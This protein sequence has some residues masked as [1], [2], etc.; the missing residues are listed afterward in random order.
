MKKN[1]LIRKE[2][3][4]KIF[5]ILV[6]YMFM[7]SGINLEVIAQDDYTSDYS[8]STYDWSSPDIEWDTFPFEADSSYVQWDQVT[9]TEDF[10][11]WDQVNYNSLTSTQIDSFSPEQLGQAVTNM[12]DVNT[13]PTLFNAFL[14]SQGVTAQVSTIAGNTVEAV[15]GGGY[16]LR[17]GENTLNLAS[18]PSNVQSISAV[19]S[20]GD[21]GTPGFVLLKPGES[22]VMSGEDSFKVTY[23]AD[24]NPHMV[25]IATGNEITATG[26]VQ[27]TTSPGNVAQGERLITKYTLE[28]GTE[29]TVT[30]FQAG[31]Q[32]SVTSNSLT[33]Q[34]ASRIDV[35]PA[36]GNM[37]YSI[38]VF[39]SGTGVVRTEGN[40]IV[41]DV[42]HGELTVSDKNGVVLDR[43]SGDVSTTYDMTTQNLEEFTLNSKDSTATIRGHLT[44][45]NDGN[46]PQIYLTQYSNNGE[47][48]RGVWHISAMISTYDSERQKTNG[49]TDDE[50]VS[51]KQRTID[52]TQRRIDQIDTQLSGTITDTYRSQLER[53]K[54]ELTEYSS[55]LEKV[56]TVTGLTNY[57]NDQ[58]TSLE[59]ENYRIYSENPNTGF[60]E[61]NQNADSLY[62]PGS[63][64]TD[65]IPTGLV[66]LVDQSSYGIHRSS[67]GTFNDRISFSGSQSGVYSIF[68]PPDY[69]EASGSNQQTLSKRGMIYFQSGIEGLT[70]DYGTASITST[71]S[72]GS[73]G[74]IV[75]TTGQNSE[76]DTYTKLWRQGSITS[77]VADTG[78]NIVGPVSN[79]IKTSMIR[80]D[81]DGVY[82]VN[83][84]VDSEQSA[85]IKEPSLIQQL[86]DG[87]QQV[88][89]ATRGVLL[90]TRAINDQMTAEQLAAVQQQLQ[91]FRGTPEQVKSFV[92][93]QITQP[94]SGQL[95]DTYI[96]INLLRA[97]GDTQALTSLLGDT[98]LSQDMQNYL[99]QQIVYAY[100]TQGDRSTV[101]SLLNQWNPDGQNAALTA[102]RNQIDQQRQLSSVTPG[103]P[104]DIDQL[105]SI[106]ASGSN[107][108]LAAS[109]QLSQYYTTQAEIAL[110]SNDK[111]LAQQYYE[112]ALNYAE[113]A[114][115]QFTLGLE[116][117]E[118]DL[119]TAGYVNVFD[120]TN[121]ASSISLQIANVADQ[122]AKL[123]T[124]N[125]LV[126]APAIEENSRLVLAI[127][128]SNI[129]AQQYLS[130]SLNSRQLYTENVRSWDAFASE[131]SGNT[132]LYTEASIGGMT[133]RRDTRQYN[134][135]D[136]KYAEINGILSSDSNLQQQYQQ[137][138]NNVYVSAVDTH[139]RELIEQEQY[140]SAINEYQKLVDSSTI[141]SEIRSS[142][143]QQI[144]SLHIQIAS[145]A[146]EQ[147]DYTTALTQLGQVNSQNGATS[148][149]IKSARLT[150]G[151]I[152]NN[153]NRYDEA[154]ASF[155]EVIRIDSQN[156]QA[157]EGLMYSYS[158]S[159]NRAGVTEQA[160]VLGSIYQQK[161][162]DTSLTM[163]QRIE[164]ATLSA[165]RYVTA[166]TIEKSVQV[167][168]TLAASTT[169][170]TVRSEI[171]TDIANLVRTQQDNSAS[172]DYYQK[173]I[174]EDSTNMQALLG[175]AEIETQGS[176]PERERAAQD[177]A[178]IRTDIEQRNQGKDLEDYSQEDL[179]LIYRVELSTS[180]NLDRT[181]STPI[182]Y[183][184]KGI[185][186]TDYQ[187]VYDRE[188]Q[189]AQFQSAL[190]SANN[191]ER[192]ATLLFNS[193]QTA[194]DEADTSEERLKAQSDM[195]IATSMI[196]GAQQSRTVT[197]LYQHNSIQQSQEEYES[198]QGWFSKVSGFFGA[199]V[200]FETTT[201]RSSFLQDQINVYDSLSSSERRSIDA[202]KSDRLG[203]NLDQTQAAVGN[204]YE[205]A[206]PDTLEE[207][208]FWFTQSAAKSGKGIIDSVFGT[209]LTGLNAYN[210]ASTEQTE[211]M[212]GLNYR[213][214]LWSRNIDPDTATDTQI[215][216]VFGSSSNIATIKQSL[217]IARNARSDNIESLNSY[218]PSE[219]WIEELLLPSGFQALQMMVV[220]EGISFGSGLVKSQVARLALSETSWISNS[221]IIAQRVVQTVGAPFEFSGN[222]GQ[223]YETGLNSLMKVSTNEGSQFTWRGFVTSYTSDFLFNRG[224]EEIV[225]TPGYGFLGEAV[226]GSAG[227]NL[228]DWVESAQ[229]KGDININIQTAYNVDTGTVIQVQQ[230]PSGFDFQQQQSHLE[231]QGYQVQPITETDSTIGLT[232][233]APSGGSYTYVQQGSNLHSNLAIVQNNQVATLIPATTIPITTPTTPITTTPVN[234]RPLT[235]VPVQVVS[236]NTNINNLAT[237]IQ[238]QSTVGNVQVVNS[239]TI[240]YTTK[241]GDINIV[242][243]EGTQ[244]SQVT[245]SNGAV[246]NVQSQVS[247][248]QSIAN[249]IAQ[250]RQTNPDALPDYLQTDQNQVNIEEGVS[251]G[252][253][254]TSVLTEILTPIGQAIKTK[255]LTSQTTNN[256]KIAEAALLVMNQQSRP[257]ALVSLQEM[258]L[259]DSNLNPVVDNPIISD[260]VTRSKEAILVNAPTMQST[261]V[262]SQTQ[263]SN[264]VESL[265]EIQQNGNYENLETALEPALF[266]MYQTGLQQGESREAILSK[267]VEIKQQQITDLN[268]F[269]AKLNQVASSF[270]EQ[271]SL[272]ALLKDSG[273]SDTTI[274]NLIDSGITTT[275]SLVNLVQSNPS[276]LTQINGVDSNTAL[277][278]VSSVE[279][280]T[281]QQTE[282]TEQPANSDATAFFFQNAKGLLDQG[283]SPSRLRQALTDV[284]QNPENAEQIMKDL[285]TE[286]R[287]EGYNVQMETDLRLA[288]SQA[289]TPQTTTELET[290]MRGT[291]QT[292]TPTV[293]EVNEVV[294]TPQTPTQDTKYNQP[295]TADITSEQPITIEISAGNT[296][297]GST[298]N[299]P[300]GRVVVGDGVVLRDVTINAQEIVLGQNVVQRNVQINQIKPVEQKPA[301]IGD[302]IQQMHAIQDLAQKNLLLDQAI[303][304]ANNVDTNKQYTDLEKYQLLDDIRA[305]G[306]NL[307][308]QNRLEDA[309]D[310]YQKG[311]ELSNKLG[312]DR[313][314]DALNS[315]LDSTNSELNGQQIQSPIQS[316]ESLE[317]IIDP[318]RLTIQLDAYKAYLDGDL[319]A[320]DILGKIYPSLIELKSS[321]FDTNTGKEI[322]QQ[323]KLDQAFNLF[324]KEFLTFVEQQ[325]ITKDNIDPIILDYKN[326]RQA[327]VES[328]DKQ[329]AENPQSEPT[330]V[331][332]ALRDN[333]L[334][335][336]RHAVDIIANRVNEKAF[337]EINTNRQLD[338]I[339]SYYQT[340]RKILSVPSLAVTFLGLNPS[341]QFGFVR[342]YETSSYLN[343]LRSI[344][345]PQASQLILKY[346]TLEK[347]N[348][349]SV[350]ESQNLLNLLMTEV[351]FADQ[352]GDIGKL[353]SYL[354]NYY[355]EL[356]VQINIKGIVLK[357]ASPEIKGSILRFVA[358]TL[359]DLDKDFISDLNEF[360]KS[361]ISWE[362]L[363]KKYPQYSDV[364]KNIEP[365]A[366]SKL[367]IAHIII[368]KDGKSYEVPVLASNFVSDKTKDSLGI[369]HIQGNKKIVVVNLEKEGFGANKILESLMTILHETDHSVAD[370]ISPTPPS[371]SNKQYLESEGKANLAAFSFIRAQNAFLTKYGTSLSLTSYSREFSETTHSIDAYSIGYIIERALRDYLSDS[372]FF[373]MYNQEGLPLTDSEFRQISDDIIA[374]VNSHIS[375]IIDLTNYP[376]YQLAKI[377]YNNI[378]NKEYDQALKTLGEIYPQQVENLKDSGLDSQSKVTR[379]YEE[380]FSQSWRDLIAKHSAQ[381]QSVESYITR[382]KEIS[383]RLHGLYVSNP[384][385]KLIYVDSAANTQAIADYLGVKPEDVPDFIMFH[386]FFH[387]FANQNKLNLDP[388]TEEML[389]DLF[390]RSLIN[391]QITNDELEIFKA[392]SG[393]SLSPTE[394]LSQTKEQFT[395][396]PASSEEITNIKKAND[397][398]T[399]VLQNAAKE[400]QSRKSLIQERLNQINLQVT[401]IFAK[402]GGPTTEDGKI[403]D[404][405]IQE[406]TRLNEQLSKI[407]QLEPSLRFNLEK[408]IISLLAPSY[409]KSVEFMYTVPGTLEG[410][411]HNIGNKLMPLGFLMPSLSKGNRLSPGLSESQKQEVIDAAKQTSVKV[412]ALLKAYNTIRALQNNAIE[413][414]S[415]FED[416]LERDI[417]LFLEI[418][419][420]HDAFK[421][422][423][424]ALDSFAKDYGSYLSQDALETIAATLAPLKGTSDMQ[425]KDGLVSNFFEPSKT[426]VDDVL[427]RG[428]SYCQKCSYEHSGQ[429]T[430]YETWLRLEPIIYNFVTNSERAYTDNLGTRTS[431]DKPLKI[432]VH[433][434]VDENGILTLTYE[435]TAGGIDT[436][437]LFAKLQNLRKEPQRIEGETDEQFNQR[438]RESIFLPG[439]TTKPVTESGE[440]GIGLDFVS[441]SIKYFKGTLSLEPVIVDGKEQGTRFIITVPVE[442]IPI[443]ETPVEQ[444]AQQQPGLAPELTQQGLDELEANLLT[445]ESKIMENL[446]RKYPDKD[447]KQSTTVL[448][449]GF[450]SQKLAVLATVQNIASEFMIT[451]S[452]K[453]LLN[454]I[455][456]ITSSNDNNEVYN[457]ALKQDNPFVSNNFRQL[458]I[459]LQKMFPVNKIAE[460]TNERD[461]TDPFRGG[462]TFNNAE[463]NIHVIVDPQYASLFQPADIPYSDYTSLQD[464]LDRRLKY[465]SIP[466]LI[467]RESLID[468]ISTVQAST[469]VKGITTPRNLEPEIQEP[470]AE[471]AQNKPGL[472]PELTDEALKEF[473]DN[474]FVTLQKIKDSMKTEFPG[475]SVVNA[476]IFLYEDPENKDMHLNSAN[477]AM[478]TLIETLG[479]K[480]DLNPNDIKILRFIFGIGSETIDIQLRIQQM[481]W[482]A[483]H[484]S[485]ELKHVLSII[486]NV[487]SQSKVSERRGI[488]HQLADGKDTFSNMDYLINSIFLYQDMVSAENVFG[489]GSVY[490]NIPHIREVESLIEGL[491][492]KQGGT[493]VKGMTTPENIEPEIQEPSAE[494]IPQTIQEQSRLV[495]ELTQQGL[496][497]LEANLL[498]LESKIM[499]NLARKYPDK[500]VKQSI[501]VLEDGFDSQKLA[502]LALVENIASKFRITDS[503]MQLLRYIFRITSSND[504]NEI[505]NWAIKQDNPF[506]SNNFRQLLKTLETIFNQKGIETRNNQRGSTD[507]FRGGD[508]FNNAETKINIIVNPQYAN[509]FQ[510]ADIPYSDY[511]SL[512]D[513]LVRRLKYNSIPDLSSR[514]SLIDTISTVQASTVVKGMTIPENPANYLK[515]KLDGI[516][517]ATN[518]KLGSISPNQAETDEDYDRR[519]RDSQFIQER[520]N[521]V[522]S[523]SDLSGSI[524]LDQAYEQ[525]RNVYQSISDYKSS[526]E[527]DTQDVITLFQQQIILYFGDLNE[528]KISTEKTVVEL[529]EE[530]P[531]EAI[532]PTAEERI[533]QQ[534]QELEDYLDQQLP[535]DVEEDFVTFGIQR[536]SSGEL[537]AAD[538]TKINSIQEYESYI[539]KQRTNI[540]YQNT[541]D[542]IEPYLPSDTRPIVETEEYSQEN[543]RRIAVDPATTYPGSDVYAVQMPQLIMEVSP[544]Q[545]NF[546]QEFLRAAG[547]RAKIALDQN[548]FSFA[549][550]YASQLSDLNQGLPLLPSQSPISKTNSQYAELYSMLQSGLFENSDEKPYVESME[551]NPNLAIYSRPYSILGYSF[552]YSVGKGGIFGQDTFIV[553]HIGVDKDQA[554]LKEL[555]RQWDLALTASTIEERTRAIAEF[556]WLFM[557]SNPL[558]RGGASLGDALSLA[559][560]KANNIPWRTTYSRVDFEALSTSREDYVAQR[561]A[562]LT[563]S[564]LAKPST[565]P[566]TAAETEQAL[567][568]QQ[569]EDATTIQPDGSIKVDDSA[570]E[571]L[572]Q[573]TEETKDDLAKEVQDKTPQKD[574]CKGGS[575]SCSLPNP[576]SQ[577]SQ[578]HR[579][580]VETA[581]KE[582]RDETVLTKAFLA[583]SNQ[584]VIDFFSLNKYNVLSVLLGL[585]PAGLVDYVTSAAAKQ[586]FRTEDEARAYAESIIKDI[587][588]FLDDTFNGRI[589]IRSFDQMISQTDTDGTTFY[590]PANF[591][592]YDTQ[593]VQNRLDEL[594]QDSRTIVLI[595]GITNIEQLFDENGNSKDYIDGLFYGYLVDDVLRYRE[596]AQQGLQT[597]QLP[598]TGAEY[599]SVNN[600]L[601]Y[602][603]LDKE[604]SDQFLNTIKQNVDNFVAKLDKAKSKGGFIDL[605]GVVSAF[606]GLSRNM[607]IIM[608]TSTLSLFTFDP[609]VL[610]FGGRA[611]ENSRQVQQ[612]VVQAEVQST[613]LTEQVI[614][615]RETAAKPITSLDTESSDLIRAIDYI[616]SNLGDSPNFQYYYLKP[617]DTAES[618]LNYVLEK[619]DIDISPEN[620]ASIN[621][622]SL[623]MLNKYLSQGS[624]AKIIIPRRAQPVQKI[625]KPSQ[626][627]PNTPSKESFDYSNFI[628]QLAQDNWEGK[629]SKVYTIAGGKTVGIGHYLGSESRNIFKNL[630]GNSV[631][632]DDVLSGKRSLTDD[633][634]NKLAEYDTERH[635]ER[636][637]ALFPRFDSYPEYLQ[638]A[639][640]DSVFRGDMGPKTAQLI[641]QNNFAAASQMHL[642]RPDYKN[643]EKWGIP[644]IIQRMDY[645]AN[646]MNQYSQEQLYQ[647][648][649]I[650]RSLAS[651]A[652]LLSGKITDGYGLRYHPIQKV[653]KMH[654]GVDIQKA[655]P[656]VPIAGKSIPSLFDGV[657]TF[658]GERTD[659]IGGRASGVVVEIESTQADGKKVLTKY[660][661][662][663]AK[664]KNQVY[665]GQTVKAGETVG[666]VGSTGAVTGPHLHL[667]IAIDNKPTD[668][669]KYLASNPKIKSVRSTAQQMAML[670]RAPRFFTDTSGKIRG[671][672]WIEDNIRRTSIDTDAPQDLKAEIYFHELLHNVLESANLLRNIDP[673]TE[674]ILIDAIIAK[675]KGQTL[676]E[677]QNNALALLDSRIS[678]RAAAISEFINFISATDESFDASEQDYQEEIRFIS[679]LKSLGT[680]SLQQTSDDLYDSAVKIYSDPQ[681]TE[682]YQTD[683]FGN[684][685]KVTEFSDAIS[686]S[687]EYYPNMFYDPDG[688]ESF[689]LE[690]L[691][692]IGAKFA[693]EKPV[694]YYNLEDLKSRIRS[695][696][697]ANVKVNEVRNNPW[698]HL[699]Y[700]SIGLYNSLRDRDFIGA[701][702]EL[703]SLLIG[704][705]IPSVLSPPYSQKEDTIIEINIGGFTYNFPFPLLSIVLLLQDKIDIPPWLTNYLVIPSI[706]IN[707][708][709]YIKLLID[710]NQLQ[711]HEWLHIF[712][713]A[714]IYNAYNQGKIDS[715]SNFDSYLGL[716]IE[717]QVQRDAEFQL[718]ERDLVYIKSEINKWIDEYNAEKPKTSEQTIVETK[719]TIKSIF[720]TF[721]AGQIVLA[722]SH[723]VPK[724]YNMKSGQSYE[725]IFNYMKTQNNLQ[726]RSL[727]DIS[728]NDIKQFF[729]KPNSITNFVKSTVPLVLLVGVIAAYVPIVSFFKSYTSDMPSPTESYTEFGTNVKQ[730]ANMFTTFVNGV[731]QDSRSISQQFS[732]SISSIADGF[733]QKAARDKEAGIN[734][735]TQS[736]FP[737]D[738]WDLMT[739]RQKAEFVLQRTITDEES[740]AIEYAHQVGAERGKTLGTQKSDGT[741]D[742]ATGTYNLAD[743]IEIDRRLTAVK[744][745]T[746]DERKKLMDFGVTGA[747]QTSVQQEIQVSERS[748]LKTELRKQFTDYNQIMLL[749]LVDLRRDLFN[750]YFIDAGYSEDLILSFSVDEL[751][752]DAFTNPEFLKVFSKNYDIIKNI[753]REKPLEPKKGEPYFRTQDELKNVVFDDT[754]YVRF[755]WIK[756]ASW[757][758]EGNIGNLPFIKKME[759]LSR[760]PRVSTFT[761][762]QL[763][764]DNFFSMTSKEKDDYLRLYG[765]DRSKRDR[766]MVYF[767][768]EQQTNVELYRG[769]NKFYSN[770]LVGDVVPA[771]K[772][773]TTK[774]L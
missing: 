128:S 419:N 466:D 648:G 671:A 522:R 99:R 556:E 679:S 445:L 695:E 129:Y 434:T 765:I 328:L 308:L 153:Q 338:L 131:N 109:S 435:D 35:T 220:S 663:Q 473:E 458:L 716:R 496:D 761:L 199:D 62:A 690:Y 279:G 26:N 215:Q 149:Q 169:D 367:P 634:I 193:A 689:F 684:R 583:N 752:E 75:I 398:K 236:P 546:M 439:V 51:Y 685:I 184:D 19:S 457:W 138:L 208:T 98:S 262:A 642:T 176:Q 513:V 502:V 154:A 356:G 156:T 653:N 126:L 302:I 442:K 183:E 401:D 596:Y 121:S 396:K 339:K 742:K 164:Y 160:S 150:E 192:I 732:D 541:L 103:L 54:T 329:I 49:M 508:T 460:R 25:D 238:S 186:F 651:Y 532:Q 48:I 418:Q 83:Q 290:F 310:I 10:N 537:I 432:T 117:A 510:P 358:E 417:A 516:V 533:S 710:N 497:E 538:G 124:G 660:L 357:D 378:Q 346:M 320:L 224:L 414:N 499:E 260:F 424:A 425:G 287:P 400:I 362:E 347:G 606:K 11:S 228:G 404:S 195:N 392:I 553:Y 280:P 211:V 38:T 612:Q 89:D 453:Q 459:T 518:S 575:I 644:G 257:E 235:S 409:L 289:V 233:T 555:S 639:L 317:K 163:D 437:L 219:N 23:D 616:E 565:V 770:I 201:G 488:M 630:F 665:L 209:D 680:K 244:V 548:Q 646:A 343:T 711:R 423:V 717:K 383:G 87:W 440:H 587:Q 531:A 569:I 670:N 480:Y 472:V 194:L 746:H 377:I 530:K 667:S 375:D 539:N 687:V 351:P 463:M 368:E 514:E 609:L 64:T 741:Y 747:E 598:S 535:M 390:A 115:E 27:I 428:N 152:L 30:T 768:L 39:T 465:N 591:L 384:Y 558:G 456:R 476:E 485:T 682:S 322:T 586:K 468:T 204:Y 729:E 333:D 712:Q 579:S 314:L 16:A 29:I 519:L 159:G 237:V 436:A 620:L 101:D 385:T 731:W 52:E 702:I 668:P 268:D 61:F 490:E 452:E 568:D 73:R 557:V 240:Q 15:E 166:G 614:T 1:K 628:K 767:Q 571:P 407:N 336:R 501:T 421:E 130:D 90:V 745:L 88:R 623:E 567:T 301:G 444:P 543:L 674:E 216:Q 274:N 763:E 283:V 467:S 737:K 601:N 226:G 675:T 72:D 9:F 694:T 627:Q 683:E 353:E 547:F 379:L 167:Y 96:N 733:R 114:R 433:R 12:G 534:R 285:L 447:V 438:I 4:V 693:E 559:L 269:N 337:N 766:V 300:N 594:Q 155:S 359:K 366:L 540:A 34:K 258:G 429:S 361:S 239:D 560:Q 545:G 206:I 350:E 714:V 323:D 600:E 203:Q 635:L 295:V 178:T 179:L 585:R 647:N 119:N 243:R 134:E 145:D 267:I 588:A 718:S 363:N 707:P 77:G 578:E 207:S 352:K 22:I 471:T 491:T 210:D 370:A 381:P 700:R 105:K 615:Q 661:H 771:V 284:Q 506:V 250:T 757:P 86:T 293:Q 564:I 643:A 318:D 574:D 82:A 205:S 158:K 706:I 577:Q 288:A 59:Q 294:T 743:W 313:F 227:G 420:S 720:W 348:Q 703:S 200:S 748:D 14:S 68:S 481:K 324:D 148:D 589:R 212:I 734:R 330:I 403:L 500:D 70:G 127:D 55:F 662:L 650:A 617:G 597:N 256:E 95:L 621:S 18:I 760:G 699:V 618:I 232:V 762:K 740:A 595:Q 652:Q 321:N 756:D 31:S 93:G 142:V 483:I 272:R 281:T 214:I 678:L 563:S 754:I 475:K 311:I 190:D 641:N 696:L 512:Q 573:E 551:D 405:L 165:Q 387:S 664:S 636:A 43:Y 692:E 592:L 33:N 566:S 524:T 515:N 173:A 527:K 525:L 640:L 331:L 371:M 259:L 94:I 271:D 133:A 80:L 416:Q 725:S 774:K 708:I 120:F 365:L 69:S 196:N 24:G 584:N 610:Y 633:E 345:S 91:E 177:L 182:S 66:V 550:A 8:S 461:S 657:I 85:V 254:L 341:E 47:T 245:D 242:V 722:L 139:A 202:A 528:R 676:N 704:M 739:R 446:A 41:F 773:L 611:I 246:Y 37:Q 380:I 111:N 44:I 507:P 7:T 306:V 431:A 631:N 489:D 354:R 486:E 180:A 270:T 112:Q 277:Q 393:Q 123:P 529:G 319:T 495:K 632:Y 449:D 3:L 218:V 448:E 53:Q 536:V 28:D 50:L 451:D 727:E 395:I 697:P 45:T 406:R 504:N 549:Q 645:H 430:G 122:L 655:N 253:T 382:S 730:G 688:S 6:I 46:T 335:I 110:Q 572:S 175:R 772:V 521:A 213:E 412:A 709:A 135:I 677:G 753:V 63:K 719:P 74:L 223:A 602:W 607:Q 340:L 40:N 251:S 118:F 520:I 231:S 17:N 312:Y 191:A 626:V 494:I 402:E 249:S 217:E 132:R 162:Q 726:D 735:E 332:N 509:L 376:D 146:I 724:G 92:S 172:L 97:Q 391:E 230:V 71:N 464:V 325:K 715:L 79:T 161:S 723:L 349:L 561:A 137:Q 113:L 654:N 698:R 275:Q 185:F 248:Q 102:V 81:A 576:T 410:F 681:L 255:V 261:V 422:G 498:N 619:Y 750:K 282:E 116:R 570:V 450:D 455:F 411:R 511:T 100:E 482:S 769:T 669:V 749:K 469:V 305:L 755:E 141:S 108:A 13:N 241:T 686:P 374:L 673:E 136:Q 599:N 252:A 225:Y 394:I 517:K 181:A 278:I 526:A 151:S 84:L 408:D 229:G 264:Q 764:K 713:K 705:P 171:Y 590:Y 649:L 470:S 758:S 736:P 487:F 2:N 247:N 20:G 656:N 125:L 65:L 198:E 265:K 625:E 263:I 608:L 562:V 477:I 637:R 309:I 441:Q 334:S 603:T 604:A 624:I 744:T 443:Q 426:N 399:I 147:N 292:T 454:Y 638:F 388:D 373:K 36:D 666:F 197:Y 140:S 658:V 222:L 60:I 316:L 189:D 168:E 157:R 57:I 505:Y 104:T 303:S 659:T 728:F 144:S 174:D 493:V 397:I 276:Y 296:V 738:Q 386:E 629:R 107:L 58:I 372:D 605:S 298:I 544:S 369:T 355:S 188:N 552:S 78:I 32:A 582:I 484:G 273:V 307:G 503:E 106:S 21:L 304:L 291:S 622:L 691:R 389:A 286:I 613:S 427:A 479:I 492:P 462:D 221:A 67:D 413:E 478:L 415:N 759:T 554:V 143:K 299:V 326:I 42:T 593:A 474:L 315:G 364:L 581:V 342:A 327:R 701:F 297:R 360:A 580:A 266:E 5:A 523:L 751:I 344:V 170:K 187:P 234:N 56:N 721:D 672:F 542:Q 76:G